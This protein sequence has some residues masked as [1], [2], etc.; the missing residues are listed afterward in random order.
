MKADTAPPDGHPLQPALDRARALARNGE[1]EAAKQLYVTLIGHDPTHR[2]ALV[3]LGALALASNHLA[4]ARTAYGQAVH[5]HPADPVA[6]TG[7]ANLLADEDP[8]TAR[9]LYARA[10]Q[11]DPNYPPAHQ[12]LA[13]LLADAGEH[14]AAAP[15]WQRGFRNHAVHPSRHRGP[16]GRSR[17]LLLTAAR[18]GNIPTRH[19]IDEARFAVTALYADFHDAG[20]G[21]PP[22]DL[23]LNAI[24]DADLV[25]EALTAAERLA[26]GS[27]APVINSPALVRRT[28]RAANAARLAVI[29]HLRAAAIRTIHRAR[30]P[31]P[32]TLRYPVL[33]RAPGFHT[34]R[35]FLRVDRAT[36]LAPAL[37]TLPG[38]ELLLID[39]LDARG[40]DGLSRKYRV[41]VISGALYPVHLAISPDWKVHY[42]TSA[43]A[44]DAAH[45]AEEQSF[46]TD[47]ARVLGPRALAA[48]HAVAATLALDYAGI[49]FAL[50]PAGNVLLFEANATMV[51]NPPE[52]DPLWDY[53]RP[54]IG[55]ALTAA[56]RLLLDRVEE[57]ASSLPPATA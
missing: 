56:R 10:L 3:E 16:A 38:D 22:H 1:D 45:R 12:G 33:V 39:H 20:A 2:D 52:P 50:D 44:H 15:H 53:R 5:H 24:G 28:G 31:D 55:A 32:A 37:A 11:T 23:L 18:G 26:A 57:R 47:P 25:P 6:L 9:R 17:L 19:W 46:L 14:E 34:G 43:M 8:P 49:D 13:R 29:P 40:P 21:L 4:A 48:L 27:P 35:H 42:V 36:D 51:L 41:M 7:L 30:P 54:A